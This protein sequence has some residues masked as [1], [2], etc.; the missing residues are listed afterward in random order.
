ML[1]HFKLFIFNRWQVVLWF[2]N[3][4]LLVQ[5]NSQKSTNQTMLSL[6]YTFNCGNAQAKL[7]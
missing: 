2:T 6:Q 5:K 3:T 4:K 7:Q 1:V